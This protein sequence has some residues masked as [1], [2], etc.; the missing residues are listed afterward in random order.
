MTAS[1]DSY[2]KF[3][4]LNKGQ[5]AGKI[6]TLSKCYDMHLSRSETTIASGHNDCGI[7]VWNSKTKEVVSKIDGAHGDPVSCVR[8]TP[9]ENYIVSTSKDDC[10]KVWDVRTCKLVNSFE[11]PKFKVGSYNNKFCI[12][13]NSQYVV[14]GCKDGSV[15]FYDLKIGECEGIVQE[16]HKTQVVACEWQPNPEGYY[17][18]ATAD[19]LGGLLFWTS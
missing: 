3:W 13:P 1:Y 10:L 9:D 19:D 4:D 14:C 7:K 16:Q 18:L 5:L 15:V 8:F 6:N 11:H 12:S 2:I 17:K